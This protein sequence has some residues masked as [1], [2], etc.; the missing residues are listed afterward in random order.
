MEGGERAATTK[1][2]RERER[3]SK[4]ARGVRRNKSSCH[5][6]NRRPTPAEGLRALRSLVIQEGWTLV[7]LSVYSQAVN[8]ETFEVIIDSRT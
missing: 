1:A 5:H 8:L 2:W 7:R 4:Q 6:A 3:A